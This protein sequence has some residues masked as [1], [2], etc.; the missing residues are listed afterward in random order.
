LQLARLVGARGL[1][2]VQEA[3]GAIVVAEIAIDTVAI[4]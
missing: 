3:L 1:W 4:A 2:L